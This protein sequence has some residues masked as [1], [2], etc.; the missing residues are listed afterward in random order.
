MVVMP[1]TPARGTR[2]AFANRV[3]SRIFFRTMQE[4]APKKATE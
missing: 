2:L 4:I 1:L 3:H